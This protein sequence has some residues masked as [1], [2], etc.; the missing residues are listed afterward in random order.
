[1]FPIY[2]V[3]IILV[4]NAVDKYLYIIFL[5]GDMLYFKCS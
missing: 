4:S 2:N 3:Q 1:M 5:G